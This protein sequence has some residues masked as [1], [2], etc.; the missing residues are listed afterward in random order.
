[1]LL[2]WR[3]Q[4]LQSFEEGLVIILVSSWIFTCRQLHRRT[5]S[6]LNHMFTNHIRAN[7]GSQ[8]T[9]KTPAYKLLQSKPRSVDTTPTQTKY[10][11]NHNSRASSVDT[12]PKQ[13][14]NTANHNSHRGHVPASE[15]MT[16]EIHKQ[17][18]YN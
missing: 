6:I 11:A 12:T 3:N 17:P 13:T 2:Q 9:S 10:T 5:N 1:M 15:M 4:L 7:K 18:M 16:G 8:S 14:E